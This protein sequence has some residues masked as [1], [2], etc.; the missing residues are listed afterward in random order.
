[1]IALVFRRPDTA[2]ERAARERAALAARRE[3]RIAVLLH[4]AAVL[5]ED[6]SS[7]ALINGTH[8]AYTALSDEETIVLG[9]LLRKVCPCAPCATAIGSAVLQMGTTLP[10]HQN[11]GP[12]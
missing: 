7:P 10:G 4:N 3:K 12:R 8:P 6:S 9:Y 11:G 5:M 1:M 2:K